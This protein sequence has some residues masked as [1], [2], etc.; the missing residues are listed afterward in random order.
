MK[1][2]LQHVYKIQ[3]EIITVKR[4]HNLKNIA[5]EWMSLGVG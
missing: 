3:F 2:E 1:N 5:A 4:A